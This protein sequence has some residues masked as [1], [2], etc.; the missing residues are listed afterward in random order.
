MRSLPLAETKIYKDNKEIKQND[1]ISIEKSPDS[2]NKYLIK[3]KN[4][5]STDAGVYKLVAS[6]KHGSSNC[7]S[8]LSVSGAPFFIRKPNS[9]L[10]VPEK[11]LIKAEFEVGGI[12]A[13][14]ISW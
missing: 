7:Q 11:K 5:E 12:P 10:S 9:V 6:N 14:E 8:D 13:P 2:E 1:H 4:V 3:I